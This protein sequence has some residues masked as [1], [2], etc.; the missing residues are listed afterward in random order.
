M[1]EDSFHKT[2]DYLF[3]KMN[4]GY[5]NYINSK[6]KQLKKKNNLIKYLDS[7]YQKDNI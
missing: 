2:A 4:K 3:K 5:N 7:F 6:K 1:E